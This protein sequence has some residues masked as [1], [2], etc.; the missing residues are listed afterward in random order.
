M[1]DRAGDL[2]LAAQWLQAS[3]DV[4]ADAYGPDSI[5]T[6]RELFK[7]AQLRFNAYAC[8]PVVG[9]MWLSGIVTTPAILV[10]R[11]QVYE[12]QA[13]VGKAT[14]VLCRYH[15]VGDVS[16]LVAEL[17]QMRATLANE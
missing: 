17:A 16:E 11:M 9:E 10:N 12:A 14:S 3:V 8:L 6:G 7:L 5:E 15:G 13:A 1:T 4:C 2:A